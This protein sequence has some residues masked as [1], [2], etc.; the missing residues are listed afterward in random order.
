MLT[1][2]HRIF[3]NE[4]NFHCKGPSTPCENGSESEKDQHTSIHPRKCSLSLPILADVNGS[5]RFTINDGPFSKLCVQS[6]SNPLFIGT[7]NYNRENTV[8]VTCQNGFAFLRSSKNHHYTKDLLSPIVKLMWIYFQGKKNK[9]F[10]N[11]F[12]ESESFH[13]H[14]PSIAHW[15]HCFQKFE[16]HRL[17]PSSDPLCS[18]CFLYFNILSRLFFRLLTVWTRLVL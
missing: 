1:L 8:T 6:C 18:V 11:S 17:I 10:R 12:H 16:S 4:R 15:I 13:I 14:H 2:F 9:I 5:W 7:I 3:R